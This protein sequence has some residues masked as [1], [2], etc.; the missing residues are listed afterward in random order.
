MCLKYKGYALKWLPVR[1]FNCERCQKRQRAK[2][3]YKKIAYP[4]AAEKMLQ[5]PAGS[6]AWCKGMGPTFFIQLFQAVI[7]DG[8]GKI[9][10][11]EAGCDLTAMQCHAHAV[12]AK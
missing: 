4:F 3:L 1:F 6:Q 8:P 9:L 12:S 2:G 11:Y 5:Q 7:A 10:W